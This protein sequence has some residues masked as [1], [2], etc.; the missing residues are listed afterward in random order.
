MD[1]FERRR[2]MQEEVWGVLFED[3]GTEY[4]VAI[5]QG[6]EEAHD[7]AQ[8]WDEQAFESAMEAYEGQGGE[9][10]WEDFAGGHYVAPISPE[11]AADAEDQLARG[12]A[13]QVH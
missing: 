2:A 5:A 8:E 3:S 10:V 4:L 12:F 1:D 9:P 7:L 6:E 11:L 13:V